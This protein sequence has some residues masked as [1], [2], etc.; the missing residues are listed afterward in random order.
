MSNEINLM[1]YDERYLEDLGKI[2]LTEDN[3]RFAGT[4]H[5]VLGTLDDP[6]R[7]MVLILNENTCIGYFVL[8]EKEGAL[9]IGFDDKALLIRSL[10]VDPLVQGKGFAFQ[11]M[12][13]LPPFVKTH[14]PNINKIVLIVN[15]KNIPAQKLYQKVGFV[16]HS[17]RVNEIHGVQLIYRYEMMP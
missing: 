3:K 15:E 16:E 12:D 6:H 9:D 14:Y 13:M 17:S 4:P 10:A 7:R 5:D 1:F 2:H 8:H 11:E